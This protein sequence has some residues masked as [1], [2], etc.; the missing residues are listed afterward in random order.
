MN[1]KVQKALVEIVLFMAGM[2]MYQGNIF[3]TADLKILNRKIED[4]V[5]IIGEK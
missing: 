4:L 5:E 1:D 2:L 3:G